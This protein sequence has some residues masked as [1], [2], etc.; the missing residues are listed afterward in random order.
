M[1][2]TEIFVAIIVALII[3][4]VVLSFR[5]HRLKEEVEGLEEELEQETELPCCREYRRV[6]G[7][8]TGHVD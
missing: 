7:S 8:L 2:S 3:K 6:Y 5:V 4:I 1:T